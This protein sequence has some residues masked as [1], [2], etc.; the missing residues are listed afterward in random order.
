MQRILTAVIVAAVGFGVIIAFV[1]AV[2]LRPTHLVRFGEPIQQDDFSYAVTRVA[3]TNALGAAPQR[4][5]AHGTFYVVTVQVENRALQVSFEWDPSMV[6]VLDANGRQYSFSIE[7]QRQLDAAAPSNRIIEHGE[8]A[9]YQVAF[10][11]P[12]AVQKPAL[13]FSNGIMMGDVFN[14]AAYMQARVPLE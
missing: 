14:G 8:T 13:A 4:I 7:G 11:L 5:T 12:D 3:K 6:R 10:D 9:R 2:S 1:A